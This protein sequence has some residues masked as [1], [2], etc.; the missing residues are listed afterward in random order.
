MLLTKEALEYIRAMEMARKDF[1]AKTHQEALDIKTKVRFKSLSDFNNAISIILYDNLSWFMN[2]TRKI[3]NILN[4]ETLTDNIL[5]LFPENKMDSL[6]QKRI[7]SFLVISDN[8]E[9]FLIDVIEEILENQKNIEVFLKDICP[10]PITKEEMFLL[11][12]MDMQDILMD[13]KMDIEDNGLFE[14]MVDNQL[15]QKE[16][17][18]GIAKVAQQ[19]LER[20]KKK[21]I[22]KLKKD[23]EIFLSKIKYV[24]K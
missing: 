17:I 7:Y 23:Y 6:L 13:V 1:F 12:Q 2:N 15:S 18:N 22:A 24:K 16:T 11:K 8:Q 10:N 4:Y 21:I 5:E 14:E 20:D 9:N 19:E 3:Q